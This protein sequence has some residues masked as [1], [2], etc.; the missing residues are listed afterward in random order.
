MSA[1]PD[2]YMGH[3]ALACGLAS[4]ARLVEA[5]RA[6]NELRHVLPSDGLVDAFIGRFALD[7][8]RARIVEDLRRAGFRRSK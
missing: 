8:D 6:M 1:R 7:T 5:H 4:A 2:V 3:M